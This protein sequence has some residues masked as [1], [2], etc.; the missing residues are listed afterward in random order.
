MAADPRDEFRS[1]ITIRVKLLAGSALLLVVSTLLYGYVA[2]ETARSA[3]LPSIR[4]QLAD[5]AINVKGGLEEMLTAHYRNVNTW[6]RLSLMREL[7]VHD[8]DKT[9]ARF[10]A[11]VRND[12]GVYLDVVVLDADG[13]CLS[14]SRAEDI[15]TSFDG[16]TLF[17]RTDNP[18]AMRTTLEY[19][20]RHDAWYLRLAAPIPDPDRP[21]RQLGTLVAMLDR[22]VLD[23]IVVS[24]PGHSQV[25]LRL[26]DET[27]RIVAGHREPF[28]IEKFEEWRV[29][30]G[31]EA[32]HFPID[33]SPLLREGVDSDGREVIVA[34]EPIGSP[35]TI[36]L[37]GWR[38][39]A[40]APKSIVLAPVVAVR[41]LVFA[42]GIGVML[43]GLV[44]AA[45]LAS[46]L[47]RPINELTQVATRI[48]RTGDLEPVPSPR[49]HDEVGQLTFAFQRMVT[50]V[51]NANDEMVRASKLAF[52]GEMAAGI[53]HEIRTPL[54]II[55]NAAQ[56]IERRM[57]SSGDGEAGEWAVFI[58]EEAD[59][60]TRV[61]TD[62]LNFVKPVPP[63]KGD[64]DL[65]ALAARAAQMLAGE[66]ANRHA[67]LRVSTG[68]EPVVAGCDADQI[69][70]VCLNLVMNA[71]Q[72][73]TT[74]G[75]VEIAVSRR[76]NTAELAVRDRGRGI[77][78]VI[79]ER[80][81]EPFTSER[82]G[83]IGLGLAIVRRIVRA[84]SGEVTARNRE[85]AGAEF[86]VTLPIAGHPGPEE[87]HET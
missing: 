8:M 22:R 19:S 6:A 86:T 79:L 50:A 84:H 35:S 54:G 14:A 59:R 33:E 10:L 26:F 38:L 44:A 40:V 78:P 76:G 66:A 5:D 30:A 13:T 58:R 18:N 20:K 45:L 24:K 68:D 56:L 23:R 80:L 69:H 31:N 67:T 16:T 34:E 73:S 43:L 62:L 42:T 36:P 29:S 41:N 70:Q 51:A 64:V 15:G 87:S 9:V 2:Y 55:R 47:A 4:E 82:D 75:E 72:A 57:D 12:Y 83:G 7:V 81:F 39:A 61:V 46:R 65:G 63:L 25:E 11:A 27:G 48:A 77:P 3:L 21:D 52:L 17:R 53:A 1:T 32:G 60:L 71:L 37:Q 49:S 28:Q 85:R 74:G